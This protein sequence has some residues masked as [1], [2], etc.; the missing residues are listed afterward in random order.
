MLIAVTFVPTLDTRQNIQQSDSQAG[1]G[2]RD[3]WDGKRKRRDRGLEE[4]KERGRGGGES[5]SL[6][7]RVG[8]YINGRC[9]N[10]LR[11]RKEG[12]SREDC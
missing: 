7:G 9:K 4:G 1:Q 3:K 12:W 8:E 5:V 11:I 6:R 10:S 2:E